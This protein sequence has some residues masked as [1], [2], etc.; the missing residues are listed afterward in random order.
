MSL[1]SA[2]GEAD[3]APKLAPILI[4]TT[5]DCS[6]P[7]S[8]SSGAGWNE[9]MA[10]WAAWTNAQGGILKHKVKLVALDTQS[11]ASV[12]V[13]DAQQLLNQNKVVAL[14]PGGSQ[15]SIL[16]PTIA[17][18]KAPIVGGQGTDVAF[19]SPYWFPVTT[20]PNNLI[21]AIIKV[22]AKASKSPHAGEIYC[23]EDPSCA[24]SAGAL[25]ASVKAAGQPSL[26]TASISFSAPSY[27]AQCLAAQNGSV[28]YIFVA[29]GNAIVN[30]V[31]NDC[32][33]Q[34]YKPL[35][36]VP[37][38]DS[39]FLSNSNLAAGNLTAIFPDAPYDGAKAKAFLTAVAKY[40]PGMVSQPTFGE[41]SFTAW[42]SGLL[43]TKAIIASKPRAGA[44]ITRADVFKGMYT[45]KKETLG[46]AAPPL[47]YKKGSP[48]NNSCF[49][50]GQVKA[51][52]LLAQG[53]AV[54]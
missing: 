41:F 15:M 24:A 2:A 25:G 30:R 27:T 3:A 13:A 51:G 48:P 44:A 14:V 4:G 53:G 26:F 29:D 1:T 18:A 37:D 22:G 21:G 40:N 33:T 6:G 38:F 32:A 49:F 28:N 19:A 46:G 31:I 54:C 16:A 42:L 5:C 20:T 35:W 34:N 45:L 52:K 11:S 36:V 8:A 10:V 17:A 50:E 39:S 9:A 43:L 7:A 23:V 47:T 12:A